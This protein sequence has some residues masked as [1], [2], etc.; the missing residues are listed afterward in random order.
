VILDC[1]LLVGRDITTGRRLEPDDLVAE[2][3]AAGIEGGV[4][5]SLRS[6][7]FDPPSGND[8]AL[9]MGSGV[10]WWSAA[11]VDLRDPLGSEREIDRAAA[12]GVPAV[13]LAP[14]RQGVPAGAPGL[15]SCAR[16]ASALGLLLLVEG[17]VRTFGPAVAEI[18]A[19]AIFVDL[20]FYHVGDFIVLARDEP[21]FHASTRLLGN[22]DGWETVV[23]ELGPERLV[24]GSRAGWFE[25]HAVLT[26]LT[27]SRLDGAARD[28][29]TSGNLRRLIGEHP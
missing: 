6:L 16:R 26:R 12:R 4:I 22:P 24:F 7:T 18:D 2:A 29:V 19:R 21:G 23:G 14:E 8:E 20:H 17:D 25:P 28:L 27:H 9:A 3:S 1:D 13:R 11:G 15:R 10:G 5:G